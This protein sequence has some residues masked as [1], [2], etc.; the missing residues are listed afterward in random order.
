MT[1]FCSLLFILCAL[2]HTNG[3]EGESIPEITFQTLKDQVTHES[4]VQHCNETT[5]V[6]NMSKALEYATILWVYTT[7]EP[8]NHTHA[9]RLFLF[10][11]EAYDE[12]QRL[13]NSIANLYNMQ[14]EEDYW[15]HYEQQLQHVEKWKRDIYFLGHGRQVVAQFS[16]S[17]LQL[18]N[19]NETMSDETLI[20]LGRYDVFYHNRLLQETQVHLTVVFCVGTFIFIVGHFYVD[21]SL[22][23]AV[24]LGLM[25]CIRYKM[26][27]ERDMFSMHSV[28]LILIDMTIYT[29]MFY[30]DHHTCKQFQLKKGIK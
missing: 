13:A 14:Q 2:L 20:Q 10:T 6:H 11:L 17:A 12:H 8:N 30:A 4:A 29:L 24:V 23:I 7:L 16:D 27:T 22:W 15:E 1:S 19:D 21:W 3:Y 9:L 5:C 18:N 26:I 25:H 28:L